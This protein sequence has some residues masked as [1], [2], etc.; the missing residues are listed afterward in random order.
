MNLEIGFIPACFSCTKK[1]DVSVCGEC[2]ARWVCGEPQSCDYAP[3]GVNC[4]ARPPYVPLFYVFRSD[5]HCRGGVY[6]VFSVSCI[7][8]CGV[9]GVFCCVVVVV[10][11]FGCFCV[12]FG[13]WLWLGGVLFFLVVFVF[14]WGFLWWFCVFLCFWVFLCFLGFLLVLVCG[15]LIFHVF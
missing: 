7:L 13:F 1:S 3:D 5:G 9:C 4:G 12:L 6:G 10:C 8:F 11:V 14:W 2:G 15:F